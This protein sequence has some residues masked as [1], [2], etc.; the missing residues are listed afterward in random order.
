MLAAGE[1]ALQTWQDNCYAIYEEAGT[2]VDDFAAKTEEDME[3]V[4]EN[5]QNAKN[6]IYDMVNNEEN[7]MKKALEDAKQ[8]AKDFDD[9]YG[10]YMTSIQNATQAT[11]NALNDMLKKLN[12]TYQAQVKLAQQA[13]A[14]AAAVAAANNASAGGGSSGGSGGGGGGSPSGVTR[15]NPTGPAAP[16]VVKTYY[17]FNESGTD[18]DYTTIGQAESVGTLYGKHYIYLITKYDNGKKTAV[19]KKTLWSVSRTGYIAPGGGNV[20]RQAKFD[21][22]GYTGD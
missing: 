7:G 2:T 11:V 4:A 10:K 17:S 1:E 14:T 16:K 18:G 20:P 3:S 22:G 5:S 13:A 19:L 21:S 15:N 12:E 6:A 8:A 9:K